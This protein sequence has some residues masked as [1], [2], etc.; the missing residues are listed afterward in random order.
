MIYEQEDSVS[1]LKYLICDVI[2]YAY[3]HINDNYLSSWQYSINMEKSKMSIRIDE[4]RKCTINTH[5]KNI[6]ESDTR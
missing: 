5:R 2:G 1:Y 6:E 4:N 3:I